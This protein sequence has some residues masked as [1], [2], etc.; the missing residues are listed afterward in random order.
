[1]LDSV[2][3]VLAEAPRHKSGGRM[4]QVTEATRGTQLATA[5]KPWKLSG[6]VAFFCFFWGGWGW[7]SQNWWHVFKFLGLKTYRGSS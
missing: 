1:M 2:S 7:K 4:I 6:K 3:R 5:T